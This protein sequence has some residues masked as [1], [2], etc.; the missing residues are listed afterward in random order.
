M[1]MSLIESMVRL[2]KKSERPLHAKK[3]FQQQQLAVKFLE[4]KDSCFDADCRKFLNYLN[5]TAGK[6]RSVYSYA[7]VKAY[8]GYHKLV[9]PKGGN[10]SE[11]WVDVN[12]VSKCVTI[13]VDDEN[14]ANDCMWETITISSDDVDNYTIKEEGSYNLLQMNLNIPVS[15]L[16]EKCCDNSQVAQML[17]DKSVDVT[18]ALKLVF[19]EKPAKKYRSTGKASVSEMDICVNKSSKSSHRIKHPNPDL[20]S[21]MPDLIT[22]PTS[23]LMDSSRGHTKPLQ[24]PSALK[25]HESMLQPRVSIPLNPMMSP[26][27]EMLAKPGCKTTTP[28]N[29]SGQSKKDNHDKDIPKT[30]KSKQGGAKR[31]KTPLRITIPSDKSTTDTASDTDKEYNARKTTREKRRKSSESIKALDE[32][33]KTFSNKDNS[34]HVKEPVRVAVDSPG[35]QVHED[36][37]ED[38]TEEVEASTKSSKKTEV[39]EEDFP[40]VKSGCLVPIHNDSDTIPDSLP[41]PSSY[42]SQLCNMERSEVYTKKVYLAALTPTLSTVSEEES[43]RSKHTTP[44]VKQPEQENLDKNEAVDDDLNLSQDSAASSQSVKILLTSQTTR[45]KPKYNPSL[46]GHKK[47]IKSNKPTSR[48]HQQKVNRHEDIDEVILENEYDPY[49]FQVEKRPKKSRNQKEIHKDKEESTSKFKKPKKGNKKDPSIKTIKVITEDKYDEYSFEVSDEESNRKQKADRIVVESEDDEPI[50]YDQFHSKNKEKKK[51]Q[52]KIVEEYQE[53]SLNDFKEQNEE[54]NETNNKGKR[55]KKRKFGKEVNNNKPVK[56]KQNKSKKKNKTTMDKEYTNIEI[57]NKKQNTINCRERKGVSEIEMLRDACTDNMDSEIHDADLEEFNSIIGSII[58]GKKKQPGKPV[59]E[60]N[61]QLTDS[62]EKF[63]QEGKDVRRPQKRK[64]KK[65][66]VIDG[67]TSAKELDEVESAKTNKENYTYSQGYLNEGLENQEQKI[68]IE[69]DE[70]KKEKRKSIRNKNDPGNSIVGSSK[71]VMNKIERKEDAFVMTRKS[72]T[73]KKESKKER[74]EKIIVDSDIEEEEEEDE[75]ERLENQKRSI[76]KENDEQKNKKEK[77]SIRNENDSAN[78]IVGTSTP[79]ISRIERNEDTYEM[80]GKKRSRVSETKSK[81]S[82]KERPKQI[83]VES[84]TEEDEEEERLE[85]HKRK[86]LK[87]NDE[88]K[89]RDKRKIIRNENDPGNSIVGAPKPDMNR[90]ERSEDTCKIT[91][92]NKGRVYETMNK[93]SIKE[94]SEEIIV[95]SD[96]EEEEEDPDNNVDVSTPPDDAQSVASF[97]KMCQILLTDVKRPKR[98]RKSVSYQDRGSSVDDNPSVGSAENLSTEM[99]EELN[100]GVTRAPMKKLSYTSENDAVSTVSRRSWLIEKQKKQVST[101]SKGHTNVWVQHS[102]RAAVYASPWISDSSKKA[103][104]KRN[105]KRSHPKKSQKR[106]SSVENQ[107]LEPITIEDNSSDINEQDDAKRRK[108]V[109]RE[110]ELVHVKEKRKQV[111]VKGKTK[112]ASN[113]TTPAHDISKK[114]PMA[115]HK[116]LSNQED[117]SEQSNLYF[118][119]S[120]NEFNSSAKSTTSSNNSGKEHPVELMNFNFDFEEDFMAEDEEEEEEEAEMLKTPALPEKTNSDHSSYKTPMV[121]KSVRI[122][123]KEV[124]DAVINSNASGPSKN[125]RP[126]KSTLKRKYEQEIEDE[127]DAEDEPEEEQDVTIYEMMEKQSARRKSSLLI[128]KKLFQLDQEEADDDYLKEGHKD[129]ADEVDD[130]EDLMMTPSCSTQFR[131]SDNEEIGEIQQLLHFVGGTI[132]KQIQAKQN[133]TKL[134]TGCAINT[135]TKHVKSLW[136]YQQTRLK[137]FE[138]IKKKILAEV[139]SLEED[140]ESMKRVEQKSMKLM[141]QLQDK[142]TAKLD[143]NITDMRNLHQEFQEKRLKLEGCLQKQLRNGF[144]NIISQE[145]TELKNRL[146]EDSKHQELMQMKRSLSSFFTSV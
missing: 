132:K 117:T 145:M 62:D 54:K 109:E 110:D 14:D 128:P 105:K 80:T 133:Q 135:A 24:L 120:E 29:G 106:L 8:L 28:A 66:E 82:K 3:W 87:G 59:Y 61:T 122:N 131:G 25:T 31:V 45:A 141:K 55:G 75:E 104:G 26:A 101:Y 2:V 96:T 143:Q 144:D 69:N 74:P 134:L 91:G 50:P 16:F 94:R 38:V 139:I 30:P 108:T 34:V 89:K 124:Q 64:Q 76:L 9:V 92:E 138:A 107:F 126:S 19:G 140:L 58:K 71:L 121:K 20:M 116:I 98:S 41:I 12:S 17:F 95:D 85:N 15:D 115:P 125:P 37:G 137:E 67:V 118:Q 39:D 113:E 5:E 102:S 4:I 23:R 68:L 73:K 56:G 119:V 7:A 49:D 47:Q 6:R 127:S 21:Q 79:G 129:R 1:Q 13:Y 130:A 112:T 83:I 36:I 57:G 103:D 78:S 65:E 48:V 136:S 84:D 43:S 97:T 51:A 44:M 63:L 114:Q 32:N 111:H 40:V 46:G 123:Q 35:C 33:A 146:L 88:Q 81:E 11:F 53:D 72:K 100:T 10:L 70:Q 77:K 90:I 142:L 42:N 60:Q 93:Q 22:S 86:F 27:R 52:K 99:N 18:H